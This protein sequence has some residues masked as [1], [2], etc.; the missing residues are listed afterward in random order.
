MGTD[1]RGAVRLYRKLKKKT[2]FPKLYIH[3]YSEHIAFE[4]REEHI[5][6][7]VIPCNASC[8]AAFF[9]AIVPR[10]IPCNAMGKW[11]FDALCFHPC[12]MGKSLFKGNGCDELFFSM[13]EMRA[14][15]RAKACVALFKQRPCRLIYDLDVIFFEA[16]EVHPLLREKG[17]L[18]KLAVTRSLLK[19]Y[20]QKVLL[21]YKRNDL[22]GHFLTVPLPVIPIFIGAAS[23]I[24]HR[25]FYHKQSEEDDIEIRKEAIKERWH[26]PEEGP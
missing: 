17:R 25:S 5:I 4:G 18:I 2:V 13:V 3:I 6:P 7:C 23:I 19:Y 15:E 1:N 12:D 20:S 14:Y 11:L 10:R 8:D 24:A 26:A 21:E 22:I 16:N 9:S